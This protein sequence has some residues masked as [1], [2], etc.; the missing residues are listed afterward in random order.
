MPPEPR[1]PNPQLNPVRFPSPFLLQWLGSDEFISGTGNAEL[2]QALAESNKVAALVLTGLALLWAFA[3]FLHM[4][5]EI[6]EELI[7]NKLRLA[8]GLSKRFN[9]MQVV[10]YSLAGSGD[11]F[12]INLS[13]RGFPLS[14]WSVGGPPLILWS[15]C[16]A[17]ATGCGASV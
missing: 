15:V 5:D 13:V 17:A 10:P 8:L 14:P 4:R 1:A 9:M 6:R 16:C 2:E 3:V 12:L 7:R 11:R